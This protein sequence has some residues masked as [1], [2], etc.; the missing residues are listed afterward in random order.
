M[1]ERLSRDD[2]LTG[3]S[4]S[5]INQK[6]MLEEYAEKNGFFNF[7]HYT[8]DGYSGG[9]FERP[10]WK[11]M[12]ADI[13]NGKI[14]CVITKDM[15]RIGREYLQTGFYTEVLFRQQ[16][17]RFIAISNGV[18]SNDKNSSEFAPF[19]N[20]MNEWY[21]RD[22][23]C[24][25]LAAYKLRGEAGKHTGA[26]PPYGY[27]KDPDDKHHWIVDEEAA[28]VVKR[29][30]NLSI[31]GYGVGQ[32]AKL[33]MNDKIERSSYYMAVRGFG[34]SQNSYDT[35]H[36]YDWSTGTVA[37]IIARVEYMGHTVNFRTY[38]ENYKDKKKT[39]AFSE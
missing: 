5:I 31:E 15:S 39:Y 35:E 4:N 25:Q 9:N 24:K 22:C 36:P 3:D 34:T 8:D 29:I 7:V 1:Y 13:E 33:L 10:S 26:H 30:F 38:K 37:N 6:S 27:K 21:L 17:V 11:R 20:I 14:G 28:S 18:D 12:I 16:G 23:S 2:E 19:L 32:I